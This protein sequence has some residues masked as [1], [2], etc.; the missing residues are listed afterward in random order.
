MEG[1]TGSLPSL[2]PG[3][4]RKGRRVSASGEPIVGVSTDLV[5]ASL[6]SCGRCR[7]ALC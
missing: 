2:F 4:L 3:V 6:A 1:N 7:S 5:S